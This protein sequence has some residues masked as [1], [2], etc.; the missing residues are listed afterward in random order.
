MARKLN[1]IRW[2]E[3]NWATPAYG[4]WVLI[5]IAL[6]F[7]GAATNT[8]AGWLYVLSGT[9]FALLGLNM[10]D[11]GKNLKGIII[12]R[13][14]IYPVHAG[15]D[16]TIILSVGNA[17][18]KLKILIQIQDEIPA[19]L[20]KPVI[21]NLESLPPRQEIQLA[22]YIPTEKRG[23][24]HWEYIILKTAAPFGLFYASRLCKIPA[25]ATVYPQILPL[26]S[27]PLIED[28]GNEELKQ[29][30]SRPIYYSA[31]E[32]VTK[33]I[34]PYRYG[35]AFRLIHWR[36]SA[37][38][39]EL[40]VRELET[41]TSGREIIICLDNSGKWEEDD[42]EKAVIAVAS[43]YCYSLRRQL[44]VRVW[45]ADMGLIHGNT[46]VMETLAA[47]KSGVNMTASIPELPV[48]WVSCHSEKLNSLMPGSR[49]FLFTK[50]PFPYPGI[51]YNREES[52]LKQL[53]Q[54]I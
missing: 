52:L 51:V 44:N 28:I 32:G 2:L 34:R 31:T 23:V 8:M 26:Q 4:G 11:A 50:P 12:K 16:L 17:T 19:F 54:P 35:D 53:Q 47:V 41:T 33:T 22:A 9:I 15:N 3:Y 39:G 48:I 10:V 36:T 18:G 37:R 42:F 14:P 46:T 29:Q 38:M 21:H 40:K 27:C 25:K 43:L 7:F 5:G 24:Y 6:S 13:L 49:C 45:L 20:G 30:E 1:I